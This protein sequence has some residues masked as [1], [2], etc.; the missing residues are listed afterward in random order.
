MVAIDG[1]YAGS[2]GRGPNRRDTASGSVATATTTPPRR[3]GQ[4]PDSTKAEGTDLIPQIEHIVVVMQENHSYDSYFGMLG[5]GDGFT[6]DPSGKPTASNA[7]VQGSEV[8]AFHAASTCQAHGLTQNWNSSHIQ[9]TNGAMDGFVRSPSGAAAMAYWDGRDIPFYYGL[10]T[11]F[12]VCDRW[13]ASCLGQT[14]PNRRF[15]LCGS[16]LGSVNTIAQDD[17]PEPNNG[18]IVEA[19]NRNGIAWRDYYTLLPSVGL[20]PPVLAANADKCP[21]IDQFFADAAAGALP[22][23]SLVESNGATQS[24][25]APQDISQGEAFTAKVVNAMMA[26]PNWATSVLVFVYDEH[27]GY[28]DHVPPPPAIPPDD[29]APILTVHPDDHLDGLPAQLPGDYARYGMRVPAV[30]VS[31]F[32]RKDHVSHVVRDHTSILSLIEHKFNLPAL[33]NRD[34][35]ADNLLETLDLAGAPAFLTPPRFPG[36]LNPTEAQ[37]CTPGAPGPVPTQPVDSCGSGLDSRSTNSA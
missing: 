36:P 21:K 2:S 10:A 14:S 35:A 11:A 3:A 29:I 12:P 20:F 8:R 34:G 30:I 17:L 9:W 31:P 25:E 24:E 7:D 13:F 26:S 32:A 1:C 22:P 37:V 19:L 16:A 5:R 23:V 33:T 4:R 18:T 15:L 6:L 27:G 28:Y